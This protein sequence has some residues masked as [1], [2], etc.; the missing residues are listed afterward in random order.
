MVT[1][2]FQDQKC[3]EHAQE[4]SPWQQLIKMFCWSKNC[5]QGQNEAHAEDWQQSYIMKFN[6]VL[7]MLRGKMTIN[8]KSFISRF[9]TYFSAVLTL[10]RTSNR[11]WL[12]LSFQQ[13]QSFISGW[14]ILEKAALLETTF[15]ENPS[16]HIFWEFLC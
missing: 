9:S 4:E 2:L 13:L 7:L 3:F 14:K 6:P 1:L 11:F 15:Y 16:F 5:F 12:F 8:N 10:S